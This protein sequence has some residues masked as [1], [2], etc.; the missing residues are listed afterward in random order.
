M[1][2]REGR[3]QLLVLH[4]S[5]I[6]EG[7]CFCF[8]AEGQRPLGRRRGRKAAA[9]A[10]PAAATAD[11]LAAGL[12]ALF[13]ALPRG[14]A[15]VLLEAQLPTTVAGPLPS[16]ELSRVAPDRPADDQPPSL[17]CWT[18]PGASFAVL[19]VLDVLDALLALP[20]PADAQAAG[21]VIGA[22]LR[23][24]SMAAK[25]AVALLAGQRYLPALAPESSIRSRAFWQPLLDEPP[26]SA[27]VAA[28]AAAM[29]PVCR[30]LALPARDG[31]AGGRARPARAADR[32]PGG[33]RGPGRAR[34]DA[35]PAAETHGG[36]YAGSGLA[37]G[38]LCR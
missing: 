33:G 27:Q 29:P 13:P 10:H 12:A 24:W 34:L 19:D 30:A 26:E 36:G 37:R 4:G 8:W 7:A 35:G 1:E 23:F 9:A 11:E 22:D 32:L 6:P 2:G 38:A 18:A 21:A 17:A 31:G 25:L 3:T 16:P 5:W 20:G 15:V 14:G 28:L